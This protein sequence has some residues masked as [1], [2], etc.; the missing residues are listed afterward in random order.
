MSLLDRARHRLRRLL[1][2]GPAA[3]N[4][5]VPLYEVLYERVARE[6]PADESIG[7]GDFDLVGRMELRALQMEGLRPSDTLVDL[8]CGTGRLAVHVVPWLEGGRYIGIDIAQTMLD[9]A[10]R[11]LATQLPA[12]PC[13]VA[14]VKQT[15]PAFD[16]PPHSVDR[17][18]AYSVFTHMEHE[19]TYRYLVDALRV[20]RPGGRF[21]LSCLP[22]NQIEFAREVFLGSAQ[23]D[24][25]ARW[26]KVRN[27]ATSTDLVDTI[28]RMAGWTPLRWY[29]GNEPHI[30]FPE[31]GE[32]YAFGQSVCVLEAP[33]GPES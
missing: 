24:F 29:P 21:V 28:A 22:V 32:V 5:G 3:P 4:P 19:D 14:W 20:V 7:E 18:C 12:P 15:G 27:V 26:S 9:K 33:G 25:A 11:R 16:L 17:M 6:V 8:G 13:Q 1:D 31:T 10:R 23:D 2:P 30:R